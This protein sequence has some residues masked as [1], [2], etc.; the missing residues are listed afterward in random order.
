[1]VELDA[2]GPVPLVG[3]RLRE[4][5]ARVTRIVPPAERVLDIGLEEHV[6]LLNLGKNRRALDLK[7]E[8]GRAAL[9]AELAM[10]DVLLEGFR[11]GVLE[12]LDLAPDTLRVRHPRL[13]LGRLSGFGRTGPLAPRAGHDINYLALSG[14]LD[15]IGPPERPSVPLNLVADF[16]GGAMH[17][18]AGVLAA[19]VRRGIDGRGGVVD[20]SI[21]AGTLGLTPML[22]SL[23]AA[24][25][26]TTA[27][28]SNL[29]DGGR[30]FYRVYATADA[31]F[32]AVG[33][34]EP[35]FFANL[36][37]LTGLTDEI[38]PVRQHDPQAW[39]AMSDAFARVF[40]RR[41][42]DDW[43][44]AAATVDCCVSPVLDAHEALTHAQN[45]ANGS[46]ADDPFSHPANPLSFDA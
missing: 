22:H 27:R 39:P 31:R 4:F 8:A 23:L 37:A 1:V 28:E 44:E 9:N 24:G 10:S 34:L 18:L 26:G 17:L 3:M 32:V 2:I 13:V 14:A 21:L 19:L 33:A 40:A 35:R 46:I 45:L 25:Q 15:A 11:P 16:G 38:D 30:P 12:R 29:L 6:D 7:S 5:G 36:L 42:R 20:T 43:A 41:T